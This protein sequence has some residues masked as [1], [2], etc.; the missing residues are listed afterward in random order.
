MLQAAVETP[1][2]LPFDPLVCD[3]FARRFGQPTEPQ[4]LGWAEIVAG[5]HTLIAAPTGSGKTL[6]AFLASIDQLIRAS[7]RG[8]LPETTQVVYVSPLKALSNDIHRNLDVPLS[9]IRELAAQADEPIAEIRAAVRTGDTPSSERQK[10]LRR[11]PHI[12]VTT[13]ESLYLL[14]TSAKGREMLR[15]VRTVIVDEIHALARDKRGSHL[16]LSLERLEHWVGRPIQR[17]GLSATQ[18]PMEDIARFLVGTRD[19]PTGIADCAI[20]D[21]G[22]VRELDLTVQAPPSELAAV[23]S[24]EQWDE[25]YAQLADLIAS[26]RSTL[27]FV[28]TRR[29]AERV[30][31]RL[32]QELGPDA[33]ASHH[34]SL[35][36]ETRLSAEERLKNGQLKAVVATASLELGIDVGFVDLVCQVGTPRSIATLLQRVGRS[37][38]ALGLVPKGRLL[39]L[40]RDELLECLALVRAVRRRQLDRIIIPRAPLDVL[41]QQIVA[42]TAC[43]EW[44]ETELLATVR[45]AAPYR[46]LTPA[47]FAD[48]LTLLTNGISGARHGAYLHRDEI[49]GTLKARR[50]ARIAATS[51]GGTIPETGDFR[52]L[53]ANDRTFVGTLNEDFALESL[54][55]D[56]F[57][58]GN[59]S[60]RI[61]YVR[62]GEVTVEDAHGAPATVPFWLGEGPG[63]TNELSAEVVALRGEIAA[64]VALAGGMEP[65]LSEAVEWLQT[66]CG[67][68]VEAAQQAAR[69]VAAQQAALG[70]V[71]SQQQIVFERFF[72]ESGGMQLVIHAPFGARVNRAWGLAMRKRFCRSFDFELQAAADDNAILLSIGPQ[73]SFAIDALFGML[74][75]RNA[76]ELLVQALL[77]APMFQTR[78]RW[79]VTCA[80]AVLR[81]RGGKKVPPFLQRFRSDDLLASVFPETVGCLE[82]HSGDIEIPDHPLVRQT[83]DDCLHQAMDLDTWIGVLGSREQGGIEF[84]ARDTREPSPFAHEILNANPY[85]FLDDAPL[86]ER[87]VRALTLRRSLSFEALSDLGRLDPE[88]I[89]LVVAAAQPQVRDADELHDALLT[90]T[91]LPIEDFR[92]WSGWFDRLVAAGRAT[93]VERAGQ[94]PLWVAA[95]RWPAVSAIYRQAQA[96]PSVSLPAHLDRAWERTEALSLLVRGHIQSSG[97]ITAEVLAARLGLSTAE[98]GAALEAQEG[99]GTVMRGHYRASAATTNDN[100]GAVEWCDRRLLA[101]IHRLTLDGLRRQIQPVEATDYL[102]FL[103]AHQ[104]VLG[105][106]RPLGVGGLRATIEQLQGYE[107]PA[108]VWE[109]RALPARVSDYEPAL[110]DQLAMSGILAWGRLRTPRR[111]PED[112]PSSAGMTRAA[113]I[114]LAQREDLVW[115]VPPDRASDVPLRGNAQTVL[116]LLESRGA[117]F[118]H[119]LR[120]AADLL[121]AHLDDALQEL[122]AVGLVSADTFGAV[123]WIATR[124]R[125]S[126]D[127]KRRHARRR[128]ALAAS[129]AT[130]GRWSRF[131]GVFKPPTEEERLNR[132]ARQLLSR[133][134]VVFR[135]LLLRENS[136]PPW[137]D[138][139]RVYRRMEARGE[140]RGGR[141]VAA[142]GGEQYAL[143]G[144]VESL[145]RFRDKELSREWFVVS[146]ADPL[147]L[148]GILTDEPRVPSIHTYT[149]AM[150]DGRLIASRQAGELRWHDEIPLD[151]AAEISRRLRRSV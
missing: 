98:V 132:W 15:D 97:P 10:M 11:P 118:Y 110:L 140:I 40:T 143:P 27:V 151:E 68:P 127:R 16:T 55:G 30:A 41:A 131:P 95:E 141:F 51:S 42:M 87:R 21:V 117:L 148:A 135:D 67:A 100:T 101:R 136:T 47:A 146:A 61:L 54:A 33:V 70:V 63:R 1:G 126:R 74:S 114:T 52:V 58:L 115:L 56:I 39:P 108:G 62:G 65:D 86:E 107:M 28:N 76:E 23:C 22:H 13:P 19:V 83:L 37:G 116:E 25:I 137:G 38:H 9:G 43:D 91:A 7:R 26:H 73:H 79:N 112:G 8:A 128:G 147:N 120:S 48:V 34:G 12:L 130:S 133:W 92:H 124:D 82:N 18:R 96:R 81:Q 45:R 57:L 59:Q 123:R 24:H 144:I 5:R 46:D 142:V 89:D 80:L 134:G 149:L 99:E 93:L 104:G 14:L 32:I 29:M 88:A 60:W 102:R 69:Y 6:A 150:R 17:I 44:S 64:R 77:A 3:W 113:G 72:D 129:P 122:A 90:L 2:L 85:T 36:R 71:P 50:G 106:Q 20:I 121:E 125:A 53:T 138:L 111:D 78:W 49:N 66:E 94:G 84:I 105:D 31:H 4:R 139:V 145:R 35:A 103:A 75:P 109:T 119:E